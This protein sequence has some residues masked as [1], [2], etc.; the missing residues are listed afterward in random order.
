MKPALIR[1][2]CYGFAFC[3]GAV[4]SFYGFIA[5]AAR[6]VRAYPINEVADARST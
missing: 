2:T 6:L 1:M 3:V 4:F 5:A